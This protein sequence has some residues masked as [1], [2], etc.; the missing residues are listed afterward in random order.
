MGKVRGLVMEAAAAV[1]RRRGFDAGRFWLWAVLGS[2]IRRLQQIVD[3]KAW[4]GMA[5]HVMYG[6]ECKARVDDSDDDY[7]RP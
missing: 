4:H 6:E 5:S 1:V 2:L 7:G 3:G